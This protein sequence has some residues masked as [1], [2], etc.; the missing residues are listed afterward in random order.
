MPYDLTDDSSGNGLVLSGNKSLHEPMLTKLYHVALLG[1][2]ELTSR[3]QNTMTKMY[4]SEWKCLNFKYY[5]IEI[6]S[7]VSN[8]Q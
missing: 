1:H 5:I 7:S 2:T 4:F 8:G 3:G 6:C